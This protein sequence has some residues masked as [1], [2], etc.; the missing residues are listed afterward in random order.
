MEENG[1]RN[2]WVTG[3]APSMRQD[4]LCG[5]FMY[6]AERGLPLGEI[7]GYLMDEENNLRYV[8]AEDD[9][10]GELVLPANCAVG[11]EFDGIYGKSTVYAVG[12]SGVV[13]GLEIKDAVVLRTQS[14]FAFYQK[15]QGVVLMQEAFE[16]G[17]ITYRLLSDEHDEQYIYHSFVE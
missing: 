14:G 10:K 13:Q 11:M 9:G 17:E 2:V 8:A 5:M 6:D 3:L 7:Y 4:M 16:G 12:Y 1:I 15:K